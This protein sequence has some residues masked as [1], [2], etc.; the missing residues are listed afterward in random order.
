M[1]MHSSTKFLGGQSDA[2]SG[3]LITPNTSD[4]AQLLSERTASGA[5]LGSLENFLLLRSLRTLEL[6]VTRQ[7]ESATKLAQFLVA[8]KAV[9][10]VHH[11]SFPSHPQHQLC[12]TQM[13][14]F[15][16]VLSFELSSATTAHT[17]LKNL[18]L[19]AYATS[20]GGVHSTIDWR[21]KFDETLNPGLL[22][23]SV[24]IE[25][26]KDLIVDLTQAL[27]SLPIEK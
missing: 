19:I 10:K 12:K 21:Y 26:V 16:P 4:A 7:S 24:G 5:I 13:E 20:L 23:V 15:P 1:V 27:D 3:V 9:L 22:R 25:A 17:F 14:G 6:R 18:K 11:P 8:H 2:L